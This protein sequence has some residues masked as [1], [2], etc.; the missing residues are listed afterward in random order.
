M[1]TTLDK[2]VRDRLYKVHLHVD[3]LPQH[4][5]TSPMADVQATLLLDS[6]P[7]S[8]PAPTPTLAP[9]LIWAPDPNPAPDPTPAT[10]L[11]LAP[12]P[13]PSQLPAP[14]HR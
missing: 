4:T 7:A 3:A 10:G 1:I 5:T 8:Q 6:A 13:A 14:V 12:P 9:S 2:N 11:T